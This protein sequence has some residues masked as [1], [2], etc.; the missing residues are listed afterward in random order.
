M[1][2][3]H[4]FTKK[5]VNKVPIFS[6]FLCKIHI[7]FLFLGLQIPIFLF[8]YPSY[9]LTPCTEEK[10]QT[11]G[12]HGENTGNFTLTRV[13]PPCCLFFHQNIFLFLISMMWYFACHLF[14]Y[15]GGGDIQNQIAVGNVIQLNK[16]NKPNRHLL[17]CRICVHKL[18][19]LQTC[20]KYQ[21]WYPTEYSCGVIFISRLFSVL[22]WNP[23]FYFY[24]EHL[25]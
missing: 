8:F 23:K 25:L 1:C 5:Y 21:L 19:L 24:R 22:V 18:V 14:F 4:Q 12:N 10:L 16:K 7:F 2:N 15:W 13:W 3:L 9:Y 20:C 17:V 11:Q 6:Y